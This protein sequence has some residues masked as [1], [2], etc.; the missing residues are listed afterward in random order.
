MIASKRPSRRDWVKESSF[1]GWFLSTDTWVH[2]VLAIA[3]DELETLLSPRQ[4]RYPTVVDVGFGHGHSLLMLDERFSPDTIIGLDIDPESLERAADKVT[5]CASDVQLRLGDAT[6]ID[7]P[8]ASVDMVLCHQTLHHVVDHEAAVR[9]FYRVLKPGGVLLMAE[10]C[11]KFIHS[12]PVWL[13]FRHPNHVQKS[14]SE[15][16]QLLNDCGFDTHP[17]RISTP[18]Y[19]WSRADFGLLEKLGKKVPA[20]KEETQVNVVAFRP[21]SPTLHG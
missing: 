15:Y 20:D 18:Y 17:D 8:D 3:M 7:L 4:D 6:S 11:R 19:W 2:R 9:E 12:L 5:D 13:L 1:G 16:V 21:A 10:S 14:D